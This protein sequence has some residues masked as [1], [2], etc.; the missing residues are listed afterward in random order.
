LGDE[1]YR[2]KGGGYSRRIRKLFVFKDNVISGTERNRKRIHG[3]GRKG[4]NNTLQKGGHLEKGRSQFLNQLAR[5]E[6][7]EK[8]REEVNCGANKWSRV[9]EKGGGMSQKQRVIHRE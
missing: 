2:R 9:W 6:N 5:I 3:A 1:I 7:I 4:E 8:E